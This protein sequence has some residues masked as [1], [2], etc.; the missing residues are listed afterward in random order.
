MIKFTEENISQEVIDYEISS[1]EIS[2]ST[3]QKY[4]KQILM[5]LKAFAQ[6]LDVEADLSHDNT[7]YILLNEATQIL[8]NIHVNI[9]H[10]EQLIDILLGINL[11]IDSSNNNLLNQNIK[12]F[13][14]QY[15]FHMKN[16]YKKNRIIEN[17]LRKVSHIEE[18]YN[19]LPES[20]ES[21]QQLHFY[22]NN[23]CAKIQENTLIISEKQ[24]KVILPF[25]LK[26]IENL[27]K[28][29]ENEHLSIENIIEK[30]YT[31][32]ISY[33]KNSAIS[34]FKESYQ[35]IT[36]REK[37]S[38]KDAIMLATEMFFNYNLHP[39]VIT[40]CKNLNELDIYLSC[41]EY[42]ELEDFHFFKTFYEIA[43]AISKTPK[44]FTN[45]LSK[46]NTH[47]TET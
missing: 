45:L 5:F 34:R 4:N 33:Y 11:L 9:T 12:S 32:P 29:Y 28:D 27:Q 21:K 46:F 2:L 44:V 24:K 47:L 15:Y 40:S 1:L 20:N 35:L 36:L 42:N 14:K 10:L 6:N 41:L 13:N 7:I 23:D 43:P 37:G 19:T 22:E 39:A 26:E 16:I 17:F 31:K 3:Q 8:K 25:T 18:S 38:K 30:F